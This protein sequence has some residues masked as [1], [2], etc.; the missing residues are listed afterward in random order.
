MRT[1]LCNSVSM[2]GISLVPRDL[3]ETRESLREWF[4]HRFGG[5]V[6]LSELRPANR[7]S[8]W[9][10]ETLVFSAEVNG[11][12]SEYVVRIPP[13]G[14][15]IFRE[16]DLGA[17]TL[18]QELLREYGIPTPSPIIYEPDRDWIGS[19][20]L[21]MPRIVGHTPSDT[22]YATR[23]WLHD[24]GPEV[25][26]RAHDG[27]V[28]TL[29]KLQQ[30]PVEQASWLARPA[31]GGLSAEGA[32]WDDYVRG[33]SDNAVPDLLTEAFDWLRKRL[34]DEP[35]R[36]SI[37]WGDA[38][39]SNAIF[40]DDGNLIGALD[41]EQACICPAEADIAWW[42]ATRRQMLE[43]NGLDIDP[44]LPGFDSRTAVVGRIEELIGRKLENLDWY[45]IFAMVRMGC[46]ILRTQVLLRASGQGDPFLTRAPIL[47]RWT[48]EAIRA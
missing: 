14:G 30:V 46:C 19:K 11:A 9:S 33:G 32:W 1:G 12:I 41:W 3:T 36:L 8:G 20:F 42:L 26:R 25:Q 40:D 44:E 38:R 39:M 48:V 17:Q 28:D 23:G 4:A 31:G 29:V 34:P 6:T 47:P 5:E 7:A 10:S 37:C 43:V 22:S 15:G 27:F 24:A 18:T 2:A 45:E 13:K 35:D 16:Y 21:V